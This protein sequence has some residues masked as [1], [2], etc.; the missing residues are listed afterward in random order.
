VDKLA[1]NYEIIKE[2]GRGGMGIVYL[3]Q[4]KR[5]D[6][7]VAIKVLQIDPNLSEQ[8][9]GK[10]IKRFYKEGQ[11]LAKLTH[12]NIVSIYDIGD[13]ENHYY[14]IME[15]IEGKS[16]ARLLQIKSPFAVF[17]VLTIGIQI[18]NALS[19]I[20]EKG[21]Y[22]RDIKPGN[23]MLSDSGEAKLTDFGLAK[24]ESAKKSLTQTGSLFGSLMY[25][26]PEQALG[27]KS[28]D[29]RADIYSLGITLYELLTG[30]SPFQDE[31]I[32]VIVKKV[33]EEEPAPP[34]SIISDIPPELDAVIL[35]AVKKEPEER[36]QTVKE[37]AEDLEK[38]IKKRTGENKPSSN[39]ISKEELSQNN[40][41]SFSGKSEDNLFLSSIIQFISLNNGSGRLSFW[42]EK[43]IPSSIFVNEGNLT[44]AELGK[45]T[46]IDAIAH[47]FCW[48]YSR[49]QF[50]FKE[51]QGEKVLYKSLNDIN[52]KQLFRQVTDRL[53][54]CPFRQIL[55]RKFN[56]DLTKKISIIREE[57][58][59]EKMKTNPVRKKIIDRLLDI[60]R[61][62]TL[63]EIISNTYEKEVES[64][65]TLSVLLEEGVIAPF[66]GLTK[67]VPHS[68]LLHMV[69][70]ISKYTDKAIAIKFIGE[71]KS[72]LNL[73]LSA[74]TASVSLKQLY[75]L[76]TIAFKDFSDLLPEKKERWE[77]M[78]EEMR[79]YVEGLSK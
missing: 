38:I 58:D 24:L 10:I 26:P 74:T 2:I 59:P 37:L 60:D 11:S 48:K 6:R 5:L 19:Y 63:A 9:S 14:M 65:Q 46:G 67:K 61:Q 32:A 31:T 27:A 13:E 3:A 44:H 21:I 23:I 43:E 69:N 18:A 78:R 39:I 34:S 71:K 62:T 75:R 7:K 53:D 1:K 57:I 40:L 77:K 45:L 51:Y 54:T 41:M 4:D 8:E 36:Y 12:P 68:H 20:H 66:I 22:H 25:I 79:I 33:I 15:F 30:V 56:G 35:K 70:I 50:E 17:L 29:H 16:L 52:I 76:S 64:C 72:I 55:H 49:G 73:N 28:L 42:F 47:S